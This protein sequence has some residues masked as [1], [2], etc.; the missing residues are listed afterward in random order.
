M[1]SAPPRGSARRAAGPGCSRRR[2]RRAA[3]PPRRWHAPRPGCALP[4]AAAHPAGRV[5]GARRRR[6]RRAGRGCARRLR[7]PGRPSRPT[8]S[9]SGAI[10]EAA[11]PRSR[12]SRWWWRPWASVSSAVVGLPVLGVVDG[13][14][15]RRPAG[16][17][18]RAAHRSAPSP[19]VQRLHPSSVDARRP[20]RAGRGHARASGHAASAVADAGRL[21]PRTVKCCSSCGRRWAMMTARA[22]RGGHLRDDVLPGVADDDVGVLQAAPQRVG[23]HVAAHRPRPLR[24]RLRRAASIWP[25]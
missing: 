7:S 2:G 25:R 6:A 13:P 18:M 11:S 16:S 23:T 12:P 20:T 10:V 17:S 22:P 1:A 24:R 8:T 4:R 9:R 19:S 5:D 15:M 21:S 3:L 14:S